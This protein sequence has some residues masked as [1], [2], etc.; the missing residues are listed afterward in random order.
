MTW[1]CFL[2]QPER[3]PG[4][5]HSLCIPEG[6]ARPNPKEQAVSAS[7]QPSRHATITRANARILPPQLREGKKALTQLI[8][9]TNRDPSTEAEHEVALE[10][11]PPE[12]GLQVSQGLWASGPMSCPAA[13]SQSPDGTIARF[14]VRL[15]R[16]SSFLLL[17]SIIAS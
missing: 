12:F 2:Y 15:L 17:C 9:T 16:V 10:A 6:E 11:T 14:C 7:H 13:V 8:G 5:W 1:P 3:E 4:Q